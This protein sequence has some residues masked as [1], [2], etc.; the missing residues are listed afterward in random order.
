MISLQFY[1]VNTLHLG[2]RGD[3]L[4]Q[5]D[6]TSTSKMSI[7]KNGKVFLAIFSKLKQMI[8]VAMNKFIPT[9]IL[10]ARVSITQPSINISRFIRRINRQFQVR[11]FG[12][13]HLVQ[14]TLS[15]AKP[16]QQSVSSLGRPNMGTSSRNKSYSSDET[17]ECKGSEGEDF[18]FGSFENRVGFGI[19]RYGLNPP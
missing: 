15:L 11:Q 17:C 3:K 1:T 10:V 5:N 13:I 9:M 14:V 7:P 8:D 16:N 4:G 19:L 2:K 18:S 12:T 6:T